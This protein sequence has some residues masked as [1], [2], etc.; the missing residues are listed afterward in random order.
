[1]RIHG[2][3]L[4]REKENYQAYQIDHTAIKNERPTSNIEC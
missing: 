4:R 3:G 2:Q 1:V